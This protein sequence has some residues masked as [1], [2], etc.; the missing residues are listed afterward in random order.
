MSSS[1]ASA[2]SCKETS[3]ITPK[4]LGFS[5]YCNKDQRGNSDIDSI[6]TDSI[7]DCMDQ[8]S[9]YTGKLCGGIVFDPTKL[10]CYFK[11]A[12]V[13]ADGAAT[14]NGLILGIANE[15]QLQPL[16]EKCPGT[17]S[18]QAT[19]N[20]LGFSIYC[21]QILS[22]YD[23][24]PNSSPDC[25]IHTD[26]FDECM[27][28]CSTTRPLCTGVVWDPI[29]RL[30][31]QNCYPKN[32][33]ADTFDINRASSIGGIRI[34]KAQLEPA[35]D[36]C[37][38]SANATIAAS[39]KEIFE[40]SCEESRVGN[41]IT[42]QHV[43]SLS[44][45][46]ES[47]ANNTEPLCLGVVFDANMVNGFENCYLKST[48]GG[49]IP[50]QAG[51]TFAKRQDASKDS[52]ADSPP[53]GKAWIAGPVIGGIALI[54]IIAA[55]WWWWRRRKSRSKQ[56]QL[57][58]VPN[59]AEPEPWRKSRSEQ[60]HEAPSTVKSEQWSKAELDPTS[61]ARPTYELDSQPEI[62]EIHEMGQ[63]LE[64]GQNFTR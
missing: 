29:L 62:H 46:I 57:Q 7:E 63:G 22:G 64:R 21:D 49:S 10:K 48:I 58:D 4:G 45:C 51:F 3:H 11:N 36:D 56:V 15:T 1:T 5:L 38:A 54:I 34:G 33:S 27:E 16:S 28:F 26:T 8:C 60:M 59:T 20:G 6:G 30:G 2:L 13:T 52:P 41:D 14:R 61:I 18:T 19:Q 17:G 24:C 23:I 9:T 32:A 47:C 53:A 12:N 43:A 25:R 39:N 42:V 55:L 44:S 31:Y 40:L 37:R 35:N 50:N